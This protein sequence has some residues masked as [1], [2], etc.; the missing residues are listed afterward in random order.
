MEDG[1]VSEGRKSFFLAKINI[2][3]WSTF[4]R[5][6]GEVV[7]FSLLQSLKNFVTIYKKYSDLERRFVQPKIDPGESVIA[8]ELPS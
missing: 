4:C 5:L 6:K 8:V 7:T 2:T 3:Y 1:G